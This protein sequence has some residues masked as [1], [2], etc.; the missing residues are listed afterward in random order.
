MS[1]Q[2]LI[3]LNS[4]LSASLRWSPLLLRKRRPKSWPAPPQPRRRQLHPA[5]RLRPNLSKS[6]LE[7]ILRTPAWIA[8]MSA[9]VHITWRSLLPLSLFRHQSP[10][11]YSQRRN[12]RILPAKSLGALCL[13]QATPN[14]SIE[15]K[16]LRIRPRPSRESMMRY[17]MSCLRT[18]SRQVFAAKMKG[19][20]GSWMTISRSTQVSL[21][22]STTTWGSI[23][24]QLS[25]WFQWRTQPSLTK[26][27]WTSKV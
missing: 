9:E 25:A 3:P 16:N 5:P 12:C 23:R 13:S 6:T 21:A 22:S 24:L 18:D 2:E 27:W 20:I 11:K 8:M 15:T 19:S 7:N 1:S 14:R 26:R 10:D 17:S 4:Q